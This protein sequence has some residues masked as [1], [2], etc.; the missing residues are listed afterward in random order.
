MKIRV[1]GLVLALVAFVALAGVA[2]AEGLSVHWQTPSFSFS[3]SSPGYSSYYS[4][5]YYWSSGA[6]AGPFIVYGYGVPLY[7]PQW[8][9]TY[10]W[11]GYG[12]PPYWANQPGTYPWYPG[13]RYGW[14][15]PYRYMARA[16]AQPSTVII[17]NNANVQGQSQQEEP[18]KTEK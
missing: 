12:A 14:D 6:I 9:S 10:P 13:I 16:L 17:I 5:S 1:C 7:A 15:R 4:S 2:Q 18:D 3:Y 11:P 8:Y